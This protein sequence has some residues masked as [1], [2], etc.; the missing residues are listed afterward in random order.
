MNNTKDEDKLSHDQL[1]TENDKLILEKNKYIEYIQ[2]IDQKIKSNKF[3]IVK[4]CKIN[5]NGH[6]WT[7]EIEEGP[8]GERFTFCEKCRID[9][10]GDYFH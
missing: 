7:T 1:I 5:N 10:Y 9:Y 6:I 8:Y 4:L 2:I 3:K